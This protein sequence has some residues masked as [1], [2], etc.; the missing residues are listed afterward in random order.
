AT[1]SEFD[2]QARRQLEQ[3]QASSA[4]VTTQLVLARKDEIRY[5]DL[6]AKG[7]VPRQKF[8]QVQELVVRLEA[9]LTE[10]NAAIAQA[11]EA[12]KGGGDTLQAARER[13]RQAEAQ[14]QE[15]RIA[16]EA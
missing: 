3:A 4:Q 16:L 7:T 10:A 11:E 9:Q 15:I 12:L 14:E 5:R 1:E 8:D 13:L 6:V 2:H